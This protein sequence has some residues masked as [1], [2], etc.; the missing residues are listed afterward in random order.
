[1]NYVCIKDRILSSTLL[2]LETKREKDRGRRESDI[3]YNIFYGYGTN[4]RE[5]AC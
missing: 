4:G 5:S 2:F 1:M 3:S